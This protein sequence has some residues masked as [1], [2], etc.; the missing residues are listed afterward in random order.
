[1][2]EQLRAEDLEVEVRLDGL[3]A[4]RHQVVPIVHVIRPEELAAA[5]SV[6]HI[7]LVFCHL[8]PNPSKVL[9][10]VEQLATRFPD[11]A[12]IAISGDTG[13]DAILAPIRAG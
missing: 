12:L 2:I 9:V 8:D 6:T 4:G 11:V 13:P 5:L 3:R 10:V 1:M 7:H